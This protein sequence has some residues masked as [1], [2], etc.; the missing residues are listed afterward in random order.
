MREAT[1][2]YQRPASRDSL[3]LAASL[4]L[5]VLAAVILVT[6]VPDAKSQVISPAVRLENAA[7]IERRLKERQAPKLAPQPQIPSAPKVPVAPLEKVEF[8]LGAVV[9]EGATAFTPADFAPL[10][11]GFLATLVST[12]Q[13]KEILNRINKL[14]R[15][16]GYILA[17][18]IA[19]PQELETGILR[20]RVIEGYVKTVVFEAPPSVKKLVEPYGRRITDSRPLQLS[21]LERAILLIGDLPG[22]NVVSRL[23]AVNEQLGTYE[24]ILT[25][26]YALVDGFVDF[27][28]RGSDS[29]GPLQLWLGGGAN[30]LLGM[31]ERAQA[32]FLTVPDH[33]QELKYLQF[34]YDQPVGH[35]G[36]YFSFFGYLSKVHENFP[37][38]LL[39]TN[40]T[41]NQLSPRIWY[42]LI[43]SRQQ[44]LWLTGVF[45]FREVKQDFEGIDAYKDRVRVL[46]VRANYNLTDSFRGTTFAT[47]EVSQGLGILGAST[48]DSALRSNSNGRSDFT[49][50]FL[51]VTRQQGLGGDFGLQIDFAGQKSQE[52]LLSSEQFAIGGSRFGRA[53]NFSAIQGDDGVAVSAELRYGKNLNWP[54]LQAFQLYGYYDFGAVWNDVPGRGTVRDSLASAGGGVRVTIVRGVRASLELAKPLTRVVLQEGNKGARAFFTLSAS[55]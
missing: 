54:W 21:V 27:N 28:N 26:D 34:S 50:F 49:K 23:Q 16:H 32:S 35:N 29:V 40:S 13:I 2:L 55:F 33:P 4:C 37:Y 5:A 1:I 51:S 38:P 36:L 42:P 22:I 20:V 17:R 30:T 19:P 44:N 43:R 18:A 9:I 53:Y 47:L 14:Y 39:D 3:P 10:Y 45:D 7:D 12:A 11:E 15:D 6:A 48:A 8:V 41:A 46:R 24:L 52:A 25:I 31:G